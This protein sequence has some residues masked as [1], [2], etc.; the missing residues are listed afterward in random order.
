MESFQIKMLKSDSVVHLTNPTPSLKKCHIKNGHI[1]Q[2]R[3]VDQ[4]VTQT[5]R[6]TIS[7]KRQSKY[8][9]CP[10]GRGAKLNPRPKIFGALVFWCF[11]FKPN[12]KEGGGGPLPF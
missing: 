10:E 8:G 6:E 3:E 7:L 2:M 4:K 5:I 1:C 9:H 12:A 11:I